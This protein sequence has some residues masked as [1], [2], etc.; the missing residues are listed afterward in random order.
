MLHMVFDA[1]LKMLVDLLPRRRAV[2]A[3]GAV[4][5]AKP[6]PLDG[7]ASQG[8]NPVGRAPGLTGLTGLTGVPGGGAQPPQAF[9]RTGSAV[10]ACIA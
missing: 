4:G 3:L 5:G 9:R 2:G 10:G 6:P 8:P 1:L 7:L